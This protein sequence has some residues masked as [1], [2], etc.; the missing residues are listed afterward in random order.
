MDVAR[1]TKMGY[2]GNAEPS[3]IIPSTIAV[4]ADNN[5]SGGRTGG[6]RVGQSQGIDDLDFHI[7]NAA[8]E[9][10]S[11][12]QL[13]YPIKQGII[14]NWDNMEKLWQRCLFQHLRCEPEEHYMLLDPSL[15]SLTGTVI[16]SGDGVTHVIPVADGY[17]IGSCISHV[18]L[19]GRD[20]TSFIQRMMRDRGE[21]V[22]PE[23]ALEVARKVK[24]MHSYVCPDIVKE[25]KKYDANPAKYIVPYTDIHP[26]TKQPW[27]VDIGYVACIFP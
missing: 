12:H 5:A 27:T 2:A 24:E 25:F 16:D 11:T 21:V 19:A 18:P 17:V 10:S 4:G 15:R 26:R 14:D 13:N 22:P 1:F 9:N 20:I 7:G 3:Y 23:E 8:F 6:G